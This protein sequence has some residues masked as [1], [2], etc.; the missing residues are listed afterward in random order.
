MIPVHLL[1]RNAADIET[2]HQIFASRVGFSKEESAH[3]KS[4][5][6]GSNVF[7]P[8]FQ[9]AIN[10]DLVTFQT[11]FAEQK[12]TDKLERTENNQSLIYSAVKAGNYDVVKFLLQ[13]KANP[14]FCHTEYGFSVLSC[15]AAHGTVELLNLLVTN[16]AKAVDSLG[17][18]IISAAETG[19]LDNIKF[20]MSRFEPSTREKNTALECALSN[21]HLESAEYLFDNEAQCSCEKLLQFINQYPSEKGFTFAKKVIETRPIDLLHYDLLCHQSLATWAIANQKI[22]TKEAHDCVELVLQKIKQDPIK[23]YVAQAVYN[24]NILHEK[25]D[26]EAYELYLKSTNSW[27]KFWYKT[28]YRTTINKRK[29]VLTLITSII[30]NPRKPVREIA[31][32]IEANDPDFLAGSVKHRERYLINEIQSLQS[33]FLPERTVTMISSANSKKVVF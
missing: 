22:T 29:D 14:N 17:H 10:D 5:I 27:F 1:K 9:A 32:E 28:I 24:A 11:L 23:E 18:P 30:D 7:S 25:L 21:N 2:K 4:L 6:N 3:E 33:Q 15:A 19:K 31:L 8:L 20:L 13:N 26:L 16:G 12:S